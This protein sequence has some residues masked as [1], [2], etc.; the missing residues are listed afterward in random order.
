MRSGYNYVG[1]VRPPMVGPICPPLPQAP[2][3][4]FMPP[5]APVKCHVCGG[6]HMARDC[7][8]ASVFC[9][10]CGQKGHYKNQCPSKSQP[11]PG[12][13]GTVPPQNK[14]QANSAQVRSNAPVASRG[15]GPGG[16][17]RGPY[18]LKHM[19]ATQVNATSDVVTGNLQIPLTVVL[20]LLLFI[21][22]HQ[23]QHI[24]SYHDTLLRHV[25]GPNLPS[26]THRSRLT[27]RP[28]N[29]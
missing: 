27:R 29:C 1:L 18:H 13:N 17:A 14:R 21:L 23:G 15:R 9:F 26:Q 7:P 16:L 25:V 2:R 20:V 3:P 22:S 8:K 4:P 6:P 11:Q 10:G 28:N 12:T 24:L 19:D 5:K